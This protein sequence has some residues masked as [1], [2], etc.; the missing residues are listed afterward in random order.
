MIAG[1]RLAELA[2]FSRED[3]RRTLDRI[4]E[5]EDEAEPVE[6]TCRMAHEAFQMLDA[7]EAEDAASRSQR[8][9]DRG[10]WKGGGQCFGDWCC[11]WVWG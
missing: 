5:M 11:G 7:M 8:N 9:L 4:L 1:E 3:G 6:T 10:S 2:K